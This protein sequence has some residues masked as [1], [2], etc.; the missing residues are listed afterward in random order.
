MQGCKD[1]VMRRIGLWLYWIGISLGAL[2]WG[3]LIL[4]GYDCIIDT[5]EAPAGK[6]AFTYC[7]AV[8]VTVPQLLLVPATLLIAITIPWQNL[9]Q[10]RI[11]FGLVVAPTL[12]LL[13]R[14]Y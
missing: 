10:F 4:L 14:L 3:G 6:S 11:G 7:L 8:A 13:T 1:A 2:G 9:K 5:P 12:L